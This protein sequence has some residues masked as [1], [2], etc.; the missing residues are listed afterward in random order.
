MEMSSASRLTSPTAKFASLSLGDCTRIRPTKKREHLNLSPDFE[1]PRSRL[2][3]P[4]SSFLEWARSKDDH[5]GAPE[6]LIGCSGIAPYHSRR[7]I[8]ITSPDPL[9][10]L[11]LSATSCQ[12][13]PTA[14][15]WCI[16]MVANS[17]SGT[18]DRR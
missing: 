11:V 6:R 17:K 10:R 15:P 8:K 2:V 5:G 3:V 9:H 18:L 13:A 1:D 7:T 4:C 16:A 12:R 14:R